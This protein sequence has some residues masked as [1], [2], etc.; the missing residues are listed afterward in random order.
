MASAVSVEDLYK[1]FGVLADAKDKASE[2]TDEY[3]VILKSVKGNTSTKKLAAQFLSRFFKHFPTKADDSINA[4]MDLCEDEDISIRRSAVKEI[5]NICKSSPQNLPRLADVLVQLMQSDDE[6]ELSAVQTSL[7][8]LF[9]I[10]CKGTLNGLFNQI[11]ES[12]EIIRE[13]AMKFLC[14]KFTKLPEDI[15]TKEVE[16]YIFGECKKIMEDVTGEE[17]QQLIKLLSSLQHLQTFQGR[18][19]IVNIIGD[20]IKQEQFDAQD[21][22]SVKRV[23]QCL[24][25]A[26]PLFSKNVH[27]T[28]FIEYVCLNVLPVFADIPKEKDDDVRLDLLRS[29]AESSTDSGPKEG[30]EKSIEPVFNTLLTYMPLPPD[31]ENQKDDTSNPKFD[32]TYV[33]CL[34]YAFYQLAA[35]HPDF[36]TMEDVQERLKDFRKRLQYFALGLNVYIRQLKSSLQNQSKEENKVKIVAL[37]TCNNIN[38]LIKD[39]FHNPPSYKSAIRLSWKPVENVAAAKPKKRQ[40]MEANGDGKSKLNRVDQQMYKAPSGKYSSSIKP[41]YSRGGRGGQRGF[42][43]R[44]RRGYR[45]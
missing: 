4:L 20:Q 5:P 11:I 2:H 10:N 23:V 9:K 29:L 19:E 1:A 24:S 21:A 40:S 44:G 18:Q 27:S 45:Y 31:A 8:S 34:I 30:T 15:L 22:D 6:N 36:L 43:G 25:M 33:E 35:K 26:Q 14:T 38:I 41:G 39:L 12:D 13:R 17:F 28:T 3:D 32:F 16:D 37:K 42:R 7:L